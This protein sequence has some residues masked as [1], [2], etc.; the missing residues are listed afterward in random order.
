MRW[1]IFAA[2][3]GAMLMAHMPARADEDAQA[4]AR[5]FLA[6]ISP[7]G[8]KISF[9]SAERSDDT[10][11]VRDVVAH[12]ETP[13]GEEI[14]QRIGL[15]RL[16]GLQP[17]PSGLFRVERLSAENIRID[18]A[19]DLQT[20]KPGSIQIASLT[21]SD[22]DGARLGDVAAS[23][24][25]VSAFAIGSTYAIRI[26]DASL[27]NVNAQ[28]L[29]RALV[30]ANQTPETGRRED[31]A[32]NALL[33]TVTYDALDL[34]GLSLRRDKTNLITA[35][36]LSSAPDGAY[37]PFPASGKFSIRAADI[38]LLDPMAAMLY[39]QFGQDRLQFSL[40]SRHNYRAPASHD[41]DI[42][43]KLSPDAVLAGNC[44]AQNLNGFSPALIRQNQAV[45]GSAAILR[46]CDLNFTG[47]EFVNRWLAQDGAKDGLSLEEARAKY[48][49]GSLLVSLD[50]QTADDPLAM[51]LAGAMQIFLTQPSRLNIRLAPQ[52]GLKFPDSAATLAMLFQGRP[53]QRREAMQKL[54]LSITAQPLN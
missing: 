19:A 41:W 45:S 33:N 31:A 5:L 14:I 35:A 15:L 23:A 51:Q 24:I 44:A 36:E 50:P 27:K 39:R 30:R 26:A 28:S 46:S 25:E 40:E 8:A 6:S 48:L 4:R 11:I 12:A 18:A 49:A 53:E 32:L 7:P 38:D 10:I 22:I 13:G 54:G 20:S 52:G 17:L 9:A 3:L 37:A 16:Q 43:L 34:R 47:T 2:L 42:S 1:H 21:A 29:T